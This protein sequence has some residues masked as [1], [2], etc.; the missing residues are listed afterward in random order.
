M[1]LMTFGKAGEGGGEE[2]EKEE[3]P[4]K[5]KP[6]R[7]YRGFRNWF[8]F[9]PFPF[10]SSLCVSF[11]ACVRRPS[12]HGLAWFAVLFEP[13]GMG[14]PRIACVRTVSDV[15]NLVPEGMKIPPVING[16]TENRNFGWL[17]SSRTRG[18]NYD[19]QTHGKSVW[20]YNDTKVAK[21]QHR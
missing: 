11:Y 7:N 3:L 4:S 20:R 19:Q 10:A 9:C 16:T 2:E 12:H 21:L 18:G 6:G 8:R 17:K 5:L 1:A 14:V 15:Y 13:H